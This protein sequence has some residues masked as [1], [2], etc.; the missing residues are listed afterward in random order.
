MNEM[1]HSA[2]SGLRGTGRAVFH[3]TGKSPCKL[4]EVRYKIETVVG[5]MKTETLLFFPRRGRIPR[6][7][8]ALGT[9]IRQAKFRFAKTS[10][11]QATLCLISEKL[12]Q[13]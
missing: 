7:N 3:D 6:G 10:C 1:V 8:S 5:G 12:F 9:A 4:A 11:M 2:G 13:Q